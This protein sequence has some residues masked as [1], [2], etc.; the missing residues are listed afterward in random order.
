MTVAGLTIARAE[1]QS[2]QTLRSHTHR[3]RSGAVS[4]G[5]LTERRRTPSW[6]RSGRF[7]NWRAARDWAVADATARPTGGERRQPNLGT[8][9]WQTSSMFS[10]SSVFAIGTVSENPHPVAGPNV[11]FPGLFDVHRG[12]VLGAAIDPSKVTIRLS[13]EPCRRPKDR[14]GEDSPDKC[15]RHGKNHGGGTPLVGFPL[16]GVPSVRLRGCVGH[17]RGSRTHCD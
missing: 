3:S 8:E 15:L 2:R 9:G 7:S 4:F 17:H 10:C 13:R 5:F 6:C 16:Q 11:T 1:G 14:S 12:C